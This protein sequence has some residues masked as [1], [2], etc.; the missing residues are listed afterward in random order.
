[1]RIILWPPHPNIGSGPAVQ[2][3]CRGKG[4]LSGVLVLSPE[5]V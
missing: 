1:M 2:A 3:G 5:T 4:V